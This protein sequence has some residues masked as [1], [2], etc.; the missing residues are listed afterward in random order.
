MYVKWG[1]KWSL[2]AGLGAL[3]FR[4]LCFSLAAVTG[5]HGFDYGGILIHG[6]IFG[7]IVVIA[8]MHVAEKAPDALKSQAQGLVLILTSG[9]GDFLSI[10]VFSRILDWSRLA[11]GTHDWRLPFF[12]SLGLA[13]LAMLFLGFFYK[14][15]AKS[16]HGGVPA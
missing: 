6:L 12:V 14:G 4:Y 11:N 7:G 15:K 8:Q 10:L 2:M 3:A 9:V 5:L 16:P 1:V 13:V